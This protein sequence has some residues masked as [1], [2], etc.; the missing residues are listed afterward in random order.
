M[1]QIRASRFSEDVRETVVYMMRKSRSGDEL[2]LATESLQVIVGRPGYTRKRPLGKGTRR[3]ASGKTITVK[4]GPCN[5]ISRRTMQK[6]I[7]KAVAEGAIELILADNKW[8]ELPDGSKEF[9]RSATYRILRENLVA[10]ET[11][12]EWNAKKQASKKAARAA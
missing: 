4:Y 12:E 11:Y 10:R 2:W 1:A 9:R 5:R 7:D 3:L 8:A 6:R